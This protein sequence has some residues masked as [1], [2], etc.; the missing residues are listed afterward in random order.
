MAEVTG[1]KMRYALFRDPAAKSRKGA[2]RQL[3][4][5]WPNVGFAYPVGRLPFQDFLQPV[6]S[7]PA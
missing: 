3:P 1:Q 7:A 5:S 4:G 6:L 2:C